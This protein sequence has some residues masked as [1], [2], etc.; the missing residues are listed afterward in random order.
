M[1]FGLGKLAEKAILPRVANQ[2]APILAEQLPKLRTL[3]ATKLR[4]DQF[5]SAY[6]TQP[7]WLAV[8]SASSGLTKLYPSLEPKFAVLMRHLRDEL[9][10]FEGESVSLVDDLP[11]KLPAAIVSGLSKK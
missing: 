10:V 8:V 2:I 6:V 1:D 5:F 7:A 3:S 4:D 9:V 11:N